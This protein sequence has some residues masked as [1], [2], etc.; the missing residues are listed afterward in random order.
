LSTPLPP[1]KIIES[2]IL[3]HFGRAWRP[4]GASS[5]N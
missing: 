2:R 3:M 5:L 4:E 1:H